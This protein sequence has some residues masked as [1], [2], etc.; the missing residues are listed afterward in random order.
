MYQFA[1][2]GF[3]LIELLVVIMI[4][5]ILMAFIV[6][7]VMRGKTSA[8]LLDC[9]NNLRNVGQAIMNYQNTYGRQMASATVT[10]G[11]TAAENAQLLWLLYLDGDGELPDYEV[12]MCPMFADTS[13]FS[14]V[15]DS[16]SATADMLSYM[17]TA[18]YS[19]NDSNWSNKIILADEKDT[20]WAGSSNHGDAT[21]AIVNGW[22]VFRVDNKVDRMKVE[23]P[24]N[25]A[26]KT[27]GIYTGAGTDSGANT[28]IFAD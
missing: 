21:G 15:S 19:S 14:T 13:D 9:S 3:T 2:K 17:M 23:D 4:I 24:D 18:N 26:D 5:S 27:N 20:A 7:A 16:A 6:P 10:T 11:T 8:K 28:F 22:T 1:K 12:F 25:D